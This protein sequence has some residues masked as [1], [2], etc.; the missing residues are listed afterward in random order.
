MPRCLARP[1]PSWLLSCLLVA[2]NSLRLFL[3]D[4]V[5]A[6]MLLG[7]MK[8]GNDNTCNFCLGVLVVADAWALADVEHVNLALSWL[9]WQCLCQRWRDR[10]G[11]GAV[12]CWAA[13]SATMTRASRSQSQSFV[14]LFQHLNIDLCRWVLSLFLIGSLD[15][16]VW[17]SV[18]CVV[19]PVAVEGL[20]EFFSLRSCFLFFSVTC[21]CF[22]SYL[23]ERL[24]IMHVQGIF[25]IIYI[26]EI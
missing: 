14:P 1:L 17:C 19:V 9:F 20:G 10:R 11:V 6:A 12:G 21:L 18:C 3:S 24:V 5:G 16:V 23:I 2:S 4:G 7:A 13:S 22:Y 25:F 26:K 15:R 8:L